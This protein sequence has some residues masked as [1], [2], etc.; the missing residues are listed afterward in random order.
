MTSYSGSVQVAGSIQNSAGDF[1]SVSGVIQDS[2]STTLGGAGNGVAVDTLNGSISYQYVYQGVYAG[3]TI[4]ISVS[5]PSFRFDVGNF[6]VDE[7]IPGTLLGAEVGITLTGSI[8]SGQTTISANIAIT[9]SGT[10][11]GT[12]FSGAADG[13][14]TLIS[15]ADN[16]A[17]VVTAAN[18]KIAMHHEIAAAKLFTFSDPNGDT[19]TQYVF[20]DLT[21]GRETGHFVVAGV[22]QPADQAIYLTPAQLS[23]TFFAAGAHSGRDHLLVAAFDGSQS[24]NTVDFVV[25]TT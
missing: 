18:R 14:G 5:T 13:S 15:A 17:P 21:P 20:E 8:D 10:Y 12:A 9:A 1:G 19:A 2:L 23:Q 6:S 4:P 7:Q 16:T 11:Q 3:G 25:R 22:R 24:S